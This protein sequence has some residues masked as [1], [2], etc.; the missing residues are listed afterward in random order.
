MPFPCVEVQDYCLADAKLAQELDERRKRVFYKVYIRH[1]C[2]PTVHGLLECRK[3]GTN[4]VFV[5]G[6]AG[7]P[8]GWYTVESFGAA[9]IV[10]LPRAYVVPAGELWD[11]YGWW[12]DNWRNDLWA[13]CYG[14]EYK[15]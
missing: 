11:F 7:Y 6:K 9:K 10:R 8:G 15:E 3:D 13:W 14:I 1:E 5:T 2:M 4:W 12:G